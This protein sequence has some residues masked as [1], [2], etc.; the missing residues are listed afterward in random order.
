[1]QK[2][3]LNSYIFILAT[4]LSYNGLMYGVAAY[5]PEAIR[6]CIAQIHEFSGQKVSNEFKELYAMISQNRV[7]ASQELVRKVVEEAC[8]IVEASTY[9]RNNWKKEAH[10]CLIEYLQSLNDRSVV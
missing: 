9:G 2:K 7:I 8:N 1:M 5:I 10:N 6:S 3:A 4:I